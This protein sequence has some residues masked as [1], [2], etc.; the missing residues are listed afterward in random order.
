[1]TL[2]ILNL[3]QPCWSP[4]ENEAKEGSHLRGANSTEV[5]TKWQNREAA[6]DASSPNLAHLTVHV[7]MAVALNGAFKLVHLEPLRHEDW[8]MLRAMQ[9]TSIVPRKESGDRAD[10]VERAGL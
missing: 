10:S 6:C 8:G 5:E 1:M 9:K 7:V 3:V 2:S 4:R